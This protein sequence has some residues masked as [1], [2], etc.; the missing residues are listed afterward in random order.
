LSGFSI[1][2]V[3][4]LILLHNFDYAASAGVNEHW[5]IVDDGV[6]ILANTVLLRNVV[7]G[8]ARFGKLGAYPYIALVAVRR[9]ALFN[10]ITAEAR[11]LIHAQYSCYTADD[12]A[13]RA[14]NDSAHRTRRAFAFA[15]TTFN[16]SRHTL[17]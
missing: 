1:A 5:P 16:A 11:A 3:Q 9:T 8:D 4:L 2:F 14:A 10:Y 6:A 15:G 17:G 7:V 13:N 12:P